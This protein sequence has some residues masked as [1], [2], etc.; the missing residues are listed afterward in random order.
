MKMYEAA[1]AAFHKIHVCRD[2]VLGT[3]RVLDEVQ[4]RAPRAGTADAAAAI[5][6]ARRARM[7]IDQSVV[8]AANQPV[9]QTD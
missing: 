4:V 2:V 7:R 5:G 3:D 1:Q 8:V 9:T 6:D